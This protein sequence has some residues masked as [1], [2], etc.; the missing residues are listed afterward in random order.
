[1]T[2]SENNLRPD[3]NN[4]CLNISVSSMNILHKLHVTELSEN[5]RS[6]KELLCIPISEANADAGTDINTDASDANDKNAFPAKATTLAIHLY[7]RIP[8]L[9]V[10]VAHAAL[11]YDPEPITHYMLFPKD[12]VDVDGSGQKIKWTGCLFGFLNPVRI[13]PVD[14]IA[15]IECQY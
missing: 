15:R 2:S 9:S 5:A 4:K 8:E 13:S 6:L 14:T 11:L 10:N 7:S 12:G 1:M 3:W